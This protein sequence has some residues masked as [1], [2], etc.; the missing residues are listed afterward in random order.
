MA[1]PRLFAPSRLTR[2]GNAAGRRR[3][4]T[5]QAV[6]VASPPLRW[7][8]RGAAVRPE[9]PM[10]HERGR[11]NRGGPDRTGS[12][13]DPSRVQFPVEKGNQ[14]LPEPESTYSRLLML[15]PAPLR[16]ARHETRTPRSCRQGSWDSLGC[17]QTLP[18][19][20][21]E[22][23]TVSGTRRRCLIAVYLCQSTTM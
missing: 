14:P 6:A 7:R 9:R 1:A 2:P 12:I 22:T 8:L 15:C 16:A 23:G 20:D 19:G 18:A 3:P 13:S 11:T 10:T 4:P 5:V 17:S 21:Y